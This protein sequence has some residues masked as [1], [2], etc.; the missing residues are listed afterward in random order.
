[1]DGRSRVGSPN[2]GNPQEQSASAPET[3]SFPPVPTIKGSQARHP[4][5]MPSGTLQP[6]QPPRRSAPSQPDQFA[7]M[8]DSNG[9]FSKG[10]PPS[11]RLLAEMEKASGSSVERFNL[12]AESYF[13]EPNIL[14]KYSNRA[15][16][17]FIS[18]HVSKG[19]PP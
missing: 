17:H 9:K 4:N 8:P 7:S 10:N 11:P 19:V 15:K 13:G 1:M 14:D 5:T 6:I 12:G 2:S 18:N 16:Q 3:A